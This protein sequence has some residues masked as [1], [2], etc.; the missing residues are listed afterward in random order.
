M[1]RSASLLLALVACGGAPS[2]TIA[3]QGT[4]AGLP[5][6][7]GSYPCAFV[8]EGTTY[9]PFRCVVTGLHIEKKD[10]L[11]PWSGNLAATGLGVRLDA[12]RACTSGGDC[13]ATSSFTVDFAADPA[14][15]FRGKVAG[16][17][18]WWLSGATL[19]IQRAG[20]GGDQ[21]GGGPPA[22]GHGEE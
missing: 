20:L 2:S 21:Y 15:T 12:H 19:E 17:P 5:I 13:S 14:G 22:N 3:N 8:S 9:G 6:R 10:G 18:D 4:R 11:E 16:S 7:P 1:I